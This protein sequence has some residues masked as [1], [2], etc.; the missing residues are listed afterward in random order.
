MSKANGICDQ[1]TFEELIKNNKYVNSLTAFNTNKIII[2]KD[3]YTFLELNDLHGHILD[4]RD[5]LDVRIKDCDLEE[6]DAVQIKKGIHSITIENSTINNCST[7]IASNLKYITIENS[8]IES[9][10]FDYTKDICQIC[11][12][13]SIIDNLRFDTCMINNGLLIDE[14]SIINNLTAHKTFINNSIKHHYNSMC[15]DDIILKDKLIDIVKNKVRFKSSYII[16]DSYDELCTF[17]INKN[18]NKEK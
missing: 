11:I 15:S 5:L 14:E 8:Y 1:E 12:Y 6:R 18:N 10:K 3:Y 2:S 16:E 7:L 4:L 17:T 13:N 9:L